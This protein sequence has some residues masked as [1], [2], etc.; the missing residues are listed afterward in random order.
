MQELITKNYNGFTIEF[1]L[2]NGQLM[3]N[4]TA[5]CAAFCRRPV[6]WLRSSATSRY[7]STLESK[8]ENLTL[9]ETRQGGFNGGGGTWIHERL[10]LKLAQWLDVDFELQCDE[11]VAE[12]LRTGKVELQRPLSPAELILAQAQQLVDHERRVYKLEAQQQVLEVQQQNTHRQVGTLTEQVAE[13]A[14]KQTTIDQD[15]CSVAGYAKLIKVQLPT[16]AA[17]F[18]GK[19][20]TQLSNQLGYV[21]G[22]IPDG[23]YGKVNSYHKDILKRAFAVELP[24]TAI[25]RPASRISPRKAA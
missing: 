24:A 10:I 5:M 2:I 17:Q 12:L 6:D 7:I 22:N 19:L 9:V 4:A 14:A 8:C 21:I 23:R 16:S 20:A 11:W 15:H 13:V 3:A 25:T 1:E 18:R